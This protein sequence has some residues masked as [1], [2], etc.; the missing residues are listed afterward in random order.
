RRMFMVEVQVSPAAGYPISFGVEKRLIYRHERRLEK[1]WT[2]FIAGGELYFVYSFQPFTVLKAGA[3]DHDPHRLVVEELSEAQVQG[4]PQGLSW[5]FGRISGGS[6]AL[7]D[8][9]QAGSYLALTHSYVN[10]AAAP[11]GQ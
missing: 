11:Y 7:A 8:P 6:P 10:E 4:P 9:W 1:N 3:L 5:S 2:P